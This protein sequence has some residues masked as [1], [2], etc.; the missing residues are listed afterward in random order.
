MSQP[1]AIDSAASVSSL[2]SYLQ[3]VSSASSS[4]F[5]VLPSLVKH[6]IPVLRQMAVTSPEFATCVSWYF[7]VVATHLTQLTAQ[8]PVMTSEASINLDSSNEW[9]LSL[10]FGESKGSNSQNAVEPLGPVLVDIAQ[11][12]GGV[13]TM[14]SCY[15]L[16]FSF[17]AVYW[18][19]G[20]ACSF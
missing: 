6:V 9:L 16:Y 1:N 8:L 20:G 5:A 17:T 12:C 15:R 19:L 11:V 14:R 2:L 4:P 18:I 10:L 13:I 7:R 3:S